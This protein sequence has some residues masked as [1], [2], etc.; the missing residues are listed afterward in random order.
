MG[1]REYRKAA[2]MTQGELALRSGISLRTIL[3]IEHG[4]VR[5]NP[6]T[7]RLLCSALDL[8]YEK[9]LEIFGPMRSVKVLP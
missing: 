8:P 6:S 4:E 5:A 9:H 1:L 7:R 3:Y 2:G